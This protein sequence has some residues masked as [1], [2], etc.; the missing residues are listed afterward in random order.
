[1]TRRYDRSFFHWGL[2]FDIQLV[3]FWFTGALYHIVS[4]DNISPC[5]TMSLMFFALVHLS[6]RLYLKW[7]PP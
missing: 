7:F 6:D 5:T 3:L 2:F 4:F 1:M